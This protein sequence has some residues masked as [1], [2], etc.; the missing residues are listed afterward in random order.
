M[1]ELWGVPEFRY[2]TMRHPLAYL[3]PDD[4]DARADALL[5]Q[6]LTLLQQGQPT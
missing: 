2:V 3:T 5:E 6:V 4:I 1:A